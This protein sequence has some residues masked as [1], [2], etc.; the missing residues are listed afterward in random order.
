MA[1]WFVSTT[2][3]VGAEID[4]RLR[5]FA[6]E[7]DAKAFASDALSCGFRVEAGT[8]PGVAPRRRV[9]WRDAYDWA[10]SRNDGAIKSLYR[11]LDAFVA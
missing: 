9:G 2:R 4:W 1:A 5:S 10:Q 11:R 6:T 8:T 7:E 3:K